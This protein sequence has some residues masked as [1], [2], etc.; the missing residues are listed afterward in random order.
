LKKIAIVTTH[1]IQYNAPFFALLNASTKV[2]LKVFYTW[3][4]SAIGAK[5]DPGFG[6]AIAWDI[7]LLDGYPY[8]FV[9]N[10]AKNPGSHHF[11][12]IVNPS[13]INEIENYKPD[14]LLVY[15]WSFW[16][17]LKALQSFKGK[18]PVWFR[19]DSTLLNTQHFLKKIFRKIWLTWVYSKVDVALYPGKA[20][21]QYLLKHGLKEAQLH[22]MPHAVDN[23]RF[24]PT[25]ELKNI[26]A[27]KRKQANLV[28][29]KILIIGSG[30]L[31]QELKLEFANSREVIFLNFQ[32]QASMPSWYAVCDVF[33]LPSKSETWGLSINEAMAAGKPVIATDTCGA[34]Y[35]LI[36]DKSNGLVIKEGDELELM[37]AFSYFDKNR[38]LLTTM[39]VNA[40]NKIKDYSFSEQ[41]AAIEKFVDSN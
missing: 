8:C 10:I 9:D 1:P 35:D 32:N 33:V 30:S 27:A 6:K 40:L 22:L 36:D 29:A 3:S 21:K 31:E 5:F 15:G 23:I 41:V 20:N 11:Y 19:G 38:H 14:Y 25:A 4:Q 26:A 34:S 39:G 12:G 2:T 37:G 13:L 7:P 28:N 17:H 16:S 24:G 18:I